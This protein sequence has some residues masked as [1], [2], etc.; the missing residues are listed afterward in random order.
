MDHYLV[1][2]TVE[3][4]SSLVLCTQ[5]KLLTLSLSLDSYSYIISYRYRQ[6]SW[7][8]LLLKYGI[9]FEFMIMKAII[10]AQSTSVHCIS[11]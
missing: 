2:L 5:S 10:H 1:L 9:N 7:Y 6:Q 4:K 11:I 3:M 8:R